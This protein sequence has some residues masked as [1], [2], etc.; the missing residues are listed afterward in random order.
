MPSSRQASAVR[1]RAGHRLSWAT[2]RITDVTLTPRPVMPRT[3]I[4][5]EA[6]MIMAAIMDICRPARIADSDI[7]RRKRRVDSS[8]RMFMKDR[9]SVVSGKSGAVRVDLGCRRI[10]QKKIN[11]QKEERRYN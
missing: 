2:A 1:N 10:I 6:Q 11:K 8:N 3:P 4:T 7:R 9:K 5:T